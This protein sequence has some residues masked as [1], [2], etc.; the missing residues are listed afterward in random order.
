MPDQDDLDY[1]RNVNRK[2]QKRINVHQESMRSLERELNQLRNT[3]WNEGFKFS[4]TGNL[5][6][7]ISG[8]VAL[9]EESDGLNASFYVGPTFVEA[10]DLLVVSFAA[11]VASLFFRGRQSS[12]VASSLVEGRRSFV[13][14]KDDIVEYSDD[15]EDGKTSGEVFRRADG[16]STYLV[17]RPFD[18]CG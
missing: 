5:S 13:G 6:N 3:L 10:D 4:H 8:R 11:P 16:V 18:S 2:Y 12:D 7:L 17:D 15:I 1:E 14:N 9:S